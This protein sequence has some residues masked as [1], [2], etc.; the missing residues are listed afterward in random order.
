MALFP[1]DQHGARYHGAQQTAYPAIVDGSVVMRERR[2]LCPDCFQDLVDWCNTYLQLAEDPSAR[3]GCAL[4]DVEISR[5]A[6]FV[7]LYAKGAEREDWYGRACA[8]CGSG[9]VP[10]VLFG[11][12]DELPGA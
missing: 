12:Q 9:V 1:C 7:T 5:F 8:T 10:L 4:C 2:R 3:R 6:V 11:R